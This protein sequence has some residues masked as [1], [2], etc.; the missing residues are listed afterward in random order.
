MSVETVCPNDSRF[1]F[2]CFKLRWLFEAVFAGTRTQ[3][4]LEVVSSKKEAV[5]LGAGFL[6]GPCV[7]ALVSRKTVIGCIALVTVRTSKSPT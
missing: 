1:S 4:S 6:V 3:M 5:A 7:D 2:L